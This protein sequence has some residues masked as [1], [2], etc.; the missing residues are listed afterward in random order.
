MDGG[1]HDEALE[2]FDTALGLDPETT[3]ALL[4][5]AN[6]RLL[7][8]NIDQAK[9]DLLKCLEIRSD[10]LLARLRLATILMALNERDAT[11]DQL[12]KAQKAVPNS[13]E[14]HSYRGEM[15]FAQGE[16]E[17]A[18]AEFQKAMELEPANPTPYVNMALVIMNSGSPGNPPDA[19]AAIEMLEKAIEV[20][21]QMHSAYMHLGQLKLAMAMDL[22]VARKVIDLY[23]TALEHC[24]T[25]DELRDICGVRLLTVAQVEAAEMLNMTTFSMQ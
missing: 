20:D 2:L 8:Q 7:Q 15:H 1:N 13:S 24:K 25:P 22:T 16:L 4:H 12:E 14:V 21:P 10:H 6:L 17:D 9:S 5:R 3:D 18:K 19:A 23:D 11:L